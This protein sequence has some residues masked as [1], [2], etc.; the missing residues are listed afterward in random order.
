[1]AAR[2]KRILI[3]D[4]NSVFQNGAGRSIP[5]I[6][7][8]CLSFLKRCE[9]RSV[10]QPRGCSLNRGHISRASL[11]TLCPTEQRGTWSSARSWDTSFPNPAGHPCTPE[12]G[13]QY[14]YSLYRNFF[15][16]LS[17][18]F[19]FEGDSGKNLIELSPDRTL[20][21]H[22]SLFCL[23]LM[24]QISA[25]VLK[26][27]W[28]SFAYTCASKYVCCNFRKSDIRTSHDKTGVD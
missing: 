12:E 5:V 14:R 24:G 25:I 21:L 22:H 28:Q 15:P 10:H 9:E 3:S 26:D 16:F 20:I 19:C 27:K 18:W 7:S 6:M 1:M 2:W 11:G 8:M 17:L 23:L 4:S 13:F